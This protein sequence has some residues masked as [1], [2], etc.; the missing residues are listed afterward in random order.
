MIIITKDGDINVEFGFGRVLVSLM[1]TE[2]K[3][4]ACV[5]MNWLK[6][7]HKTGDDIDNINAFEDDDKL[8]VHPAVNL[9]F[10]NKESIDVV[11]EELQQAKKILEKNE[12]SSIQ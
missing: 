10:W 6:E 1:A 4:T 7:D 8:F 5:R 9:N 11:I 3:K 12:D 2:D